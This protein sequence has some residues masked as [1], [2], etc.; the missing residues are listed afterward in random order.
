[1][2]HVIAIGDAADEGAA[3]FDAA[4]DV[5][6]A[7]D[8]AAAIGEAQRVAVA[9]DAVLLSP[10]CTSY[11]WY[12]NYEERGHDFTRLVKMRLGRP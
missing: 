8:M 7:G 2:R 6:R 10:G 3:V 4:V 11:D 9:G 1:V 5:T 12:R